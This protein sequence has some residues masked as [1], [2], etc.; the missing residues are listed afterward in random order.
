MN[1]VRALPKDSLQALSINV[2]RQTFRACN[3]LCRTAGVKTQHAYYNKILRNRAWYIDILKKDKK[4]G[5]Q[6]EI[7]RNQ[8]IDCLINNNEEIVTIDADGE[9]TEYIMHVRDVI[10]ATLMLYRK[11]QYTLN[12]KTKIF[13]IDYVEDTPLV[14]FLDFRSNIYNLH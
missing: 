14:N 9:E 1:P 3:T 6:Q 13:L 5:Y 2:I 8:T 10:L 4:S 7:Y 12:A 11:G